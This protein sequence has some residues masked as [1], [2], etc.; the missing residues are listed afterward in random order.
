MRKKLYD[1]N[2]IELEQFHE[3]FT[4][5]DIVDMKEDELN[6]IDRGYLEEQI[7]LHDFD[8]IVDAINVKL[9][10]N[11]DLNEEEEEYLEWGD[12]VDYDLGLPIMSSEMLLNF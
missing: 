2:Q 4:F 3:V 12:K 10:H 8:D 7:I 11:I 1:M 9:E 5:E 6:Y